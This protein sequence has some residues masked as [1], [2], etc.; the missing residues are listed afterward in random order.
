MEL[1][2]AGERATVAAALSSA[3]TTL[4]SQQ[5]AQ[6]AI[7]V[8]PE[9]V[10]IWRALIGT[11]PLRTLVPLRLAIVVVV[12][13]IAWRIVIAARQ[14]HFAPTE[15]AS[16]RRCLSRWPATPRRRVMPNADTLAC[17]SFRPRTSR[18]NASSFGLDRG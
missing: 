7:E 14:Q 17:R 1:V 3:G 10:Q 6:L 9:L 4:V 2:R 5:T 18:K 8:T 12:P 11:L 15:C 16:C 13:G